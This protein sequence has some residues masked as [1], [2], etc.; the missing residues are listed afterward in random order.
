[1]TVIKI[2]GDRLTLAVSV[3]KTFTSEC[4]MEMDATS[5]YFKAMD[6]ANVG[7]VE[8]RVT[9]NVE[10]PCAPVIFKLDDFP[11]VMSGEIEIDVTKQMLIAHIGRANYK[12]KTLTSG[13]PAPSPKIP[14]TN[15]FTMQ[16]ND[17]KFGLQTICE[18]YEK[19]DTSAA[20]RIKYDEHGLMFEDKNADL[21]DVTYTRDEIKI[22][23]EG[24]KEVS[25][26]MPAD[27]LKQ[28]YPII[29]KL[30]ECI[31]GI[32]KDLPMTISG[33]AAGLGCGWIISYRIDT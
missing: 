7:M 12:I 20:V 14:W 4:K 17:L 28:I 19:K 9:C 26:L 3:V 1:M 21:V 18:A 24:A 10:E 8:C 30:Q 16:P 27:Y 23:Q 15:I 13:P 11:S 32:G 6:I 22:R 33:N 2:P 29:G 25:I 31:I 5:L